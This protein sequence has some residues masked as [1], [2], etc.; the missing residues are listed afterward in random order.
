MEASLSERTWAFGTGLLSLRQGDLVTADS[1]AIVNAANSSL[2]GGGG[3]DGAIH[4]AAGHH[5]LLA[6]KQIVLRDGPLPAG[7]AVITP[8]F[9]LAARFVIH[10]VGPIWQGGGNGEERLL[11]SAYEKSLELAQASNLATIAFPA[12][13]CGA[14]GYPLEL[15]APVALNAL[16]QGLVL[17][18]VRRAELW[19]RGRTAFDFWTANATGLFGPA[20]P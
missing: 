17:G 11:R 13:S 2:M 9:R 16:R 18:M 10:T 15:A 7:R 19:L 4:K 12:L 20:A 6:C 5:L 8:G 1:D 3:V 14:Y